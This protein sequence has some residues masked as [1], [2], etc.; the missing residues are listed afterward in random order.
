MDF[1]RIALGI[2][3]EYDVLALWSRPV[4]RWWSA[5]LYGVSP[6]SSLSTQRTV[7]RLQSTSCATIHKDFLGSLVTAAMAPFGGWHPVRL[8]VYAPDPI[9]LWS[10][11][12]QIKVQELKVEVQRQILHVTASN[13]RS[14]LQ[15]LKKRAVLCLERK[16]DTSCTCYSWRLVPLM[17]WRVTVNKIASI[18]LSFGI[19]LKPLP[20]LVLWLLIT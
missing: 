18:R 5:T 12:C 15:S 3:R 6:R 9:V 16:G 14:V 7:D 10:W 11:S 19:C 13:C 17:W 1:A 4:S 8:I 20:S 2:T